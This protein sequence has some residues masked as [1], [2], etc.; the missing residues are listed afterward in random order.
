MVH[1]VKSFDK[2]LNKL[3]KMV[4]K[5]ME[6]NL[7]QLNLLH[8]LISDFSDQIQNEVCDIDSQINDL[9]VKIIDSSIKIL[10]LRNPVAS[11]LRLVFSSS[12]ISRNLERMGDYTKSVARNISNNEIHDTLKNKYLEA[13]HL[14]IEMLHLTIKAFTDR[15]VEIANKVQVMDLRVDELHNE[16]SEF[17]LQKVQV[18]P[19]KIA[20]IRSHFLVI[21]NFERIGDHAV[22]I[23]RYL[24]FIENNAVIHD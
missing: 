3:L 10:S 1:I 24:N 16:M 21:R 11:D 17:L 22:N 12:H 15:D 19:E 23:C 4:I 6:T 8:T 7:Y 18:V 20:E 9:D 5:M 14:L 2:D 13:V